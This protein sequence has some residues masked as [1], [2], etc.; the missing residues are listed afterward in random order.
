M[1]KVSKLILTIFVCLIFTV[2]AFAQS[3]TI[4]I[5]G[6]ELKNLLPDKKNKKPLLI[7]FWATWCG[8]CRV[9]FPELVEIDNEYREKGLN[10]VI[11]SVDKFAVIETRVPEFLQ[12]YEAKMPSYLLD[13]ETDRQK[14]RAIRQIAPKFSGNY[15]FTL[16]FNANGKL[17]Y[18]KSGVI[19]AK[20][21]KL[22]IEKVLPK[23][24]KND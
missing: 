13:A 7:N 24:K 18:Q 1:P 8:P 10:F 15:P 22:E 5:D 16:L 19:N 23:T 17:V 3:E 9:E 11:V 14:L 2:S 12:Q 20:I 21:L 4:K 6:A